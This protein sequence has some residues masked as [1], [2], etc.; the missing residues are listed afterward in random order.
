MHARARSTSTA[1]TQ[2]LKQVQYL[3]EAELGRA[4]S[5]NEDLE[6]MRAAIHLIERQDEK[7]NNL[8]KATKM[9]GKPL[10]E[11]SNQ[12]SDSSRQVSEVQAT[13]AAIKLLTEQ[14]HARGDAA[15][16]DGQ[17]GADGDVLIAIQS[18]ER[19][20]HELSRRL[21]Q[22]ADDIS[23]DV[24]AASEKSKAQLTTLSDDLGK[25]TERLAADLTQVDEHVQQARAA[26]VESLEQVA[27]GGGPGSSDLGET[28]G[29]IQGEL[30]TLGNSIANMRLAP[31]ADGDAEAGATATT[32]ATGDAKPS[33]A[34][35]IAKLKQL[36]S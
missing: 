23:N 5:R 3:F 1:A 19:I 7:I 35:A 32:K 20:L 14:G 10:L 22:K 6:S 34:N 36:R 29:R 28:L 18:F 30:S 9:Y 21:I 26:I 25:N 12:I 17:L 33:V 11:I 2:L 8:S 4:E 15:R 27:A 24:A 13:L 16:G 31:A